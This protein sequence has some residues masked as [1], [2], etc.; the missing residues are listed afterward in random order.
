METVYVPD[1]IY[2]L[3]W[4]EVMKACKDIALEAYSSF[5][6][7]AVVGIARGGLILA[8][9]VSSMIQ[10]DL[11][12]CVVTRKRRGRVIR[13]RPE[14]IISVSEMVKNQRVLVVD[15]SVM[16]GET[17]RVVS[18][19]CKRFDARIVKTAAIWVS[20][21]SW[22]P[23]IYCMEGPGH[24]MFPWDYEVLESG[25]FVLNPLYQEYIDSLEM[26]DLWVK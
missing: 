18:T 25:R 19:Q 20:S 24:I 21:E 7:N 12:P 4:D 14:T 10:T 23:T 5:R 11:F 26:I 8:S 3:S 6:P 17:M 2:R 13:T 16:T 22:K 9:I 1:S 15:E